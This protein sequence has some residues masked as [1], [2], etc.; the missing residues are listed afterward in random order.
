MLIEM[1]VT[2]RE[3]E[4]G[5]GARICGT[6]AAAGGPTLELGVMSGR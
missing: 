5:T 3:P 6:P 4:S 2:A 1:E